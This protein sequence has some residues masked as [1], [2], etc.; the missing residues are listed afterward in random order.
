MMISIHK[1]QEHLAI[2]SRLYS[3]VPLDLIEKSTADVLTEQNIYE[4]S[5][6]NILDAAVKFDL[7]NVNSKN[8]ETLIDTGKECASEGLLELPFEITY[9][10]GSFEY[11][12]SEIRSGTVFA[13]ASRCFGAAEFESRPELMGGTAA[14]NFSRISGCD[15][16]QNS[17]KA[18]TLITVFSQGFTDIF[19]VPA[20]KSIAENYEITDDQCQGAADINTTLLYVLHSLINARGIKLQIEPAPAK[21][22][23]KRAKKNKLPLHEHRVLKIGGY[24]SGGRV[25]GVG[26]THASPRAHWRRGHIRTIHQ[27][28]PKQK[29]IAI[30][31]SL[32]NGPGFVSKDYEIS[33]LDCPRLCDREQK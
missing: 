26:A 12:S 18:P 8:L 30:P 15:N 7:G 21:L 5:T 17:W 23:R 33:V 6:S 20:L 10:E 25:L 19:C 11:G 16:D 29:R 24:S 1:I 22:N 31:S 4:T 14:L 3:R 9:A 32:I 2:D 28:T 13:P 27:G